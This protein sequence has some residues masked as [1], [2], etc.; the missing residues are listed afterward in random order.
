MRFILPLITGLLFSARV[1]ANGDEP[2][3]K[4][5]AFELSV[6][7]GLD[8]QFIAGRPYDPIMAK[9]LH[10]GERPFAGFCFGLSYSYRPFRIF[11][12]STGFDYLQFGSRL[13]ETETY[14]FTTNLYTVT[15]VDNGYQ[16]SGNIGI[17]LYVHFYQPIKK[18]TLEYVAGP[19]FFFEVYDQGHLNIINYTPGISGNIDYITYFNGITIRQNASLAFCVQAL[20]DVPVKNELVISL[21]PEWQLLE[22]KQ[23][24]PP[25]IYP[26]SHVPTRAVPFFLGLK[27]GF[28][29]EPVL[30]GL[31]K[32]K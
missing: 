28:R 9:L 1:M 12:V 13:G 27:V 10:D 17:P 24:L 23:F 16:F 26:A 29:L 7:A 4:H 15:A 21:G 14:D 5:H 11:G 2:N 31:K 30:Q 18:Y 8:H 25:S 3:L 20:L 19:E 22:L 6:A 32:G